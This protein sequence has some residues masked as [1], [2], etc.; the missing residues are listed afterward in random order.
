MNLSDLLK[1]INTTNALNI[2]IN[3]LDFFDIMTQEEAMK[4]ISLL[5][6]LPLINDAT[7][8]AILGV[9]IWTYNIPRN[10]F[11]YSNKNNF[12]YDEKFLSNWSVPISIDLIDKFDKISELKAFL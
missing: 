7:R 3:R 1:I 12:F 2:C 9:K 11:M 5:P 6:P 10:Y 8:C 4:L